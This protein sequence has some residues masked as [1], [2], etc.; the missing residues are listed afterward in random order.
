[1][2]DTKRL[3]DWREI[4]ESF[5]C[6]FDFYFHCK[7]HATFTKPY[8]IIIFWRIRKNSSKIIKNVNYD[9]SR[10]ILLS[11][12]WKNW[13]PNFPVNGIRKINLFLNKCRWGE[14]RI[15]RRC[16][17]RRNHNHSECLPRLQRSYIPW[18]TPFYLT[19]GW[20]DYWDDIRT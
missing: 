6:K 17:D 5:F 20:E 19:T 4:I 14:A 7:I 18:E 11:K 15:S 16:Q 3:S 1:M 10:V 12:R 8:K 13:K 9:S 2:S